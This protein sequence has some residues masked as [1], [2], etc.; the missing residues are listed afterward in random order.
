MLVVSSIFS[1][2]Q[3][4]RVHD[5]GCDDLLAVPLSTDELHRHLAQVGSIPYRG[6]DRMAMNATAHLL[7]SGRRARVRL[8]DLSLGGAGVVADEVF[9]VGAELALELSPEA[10]AIPVRVVW[11][12]P[13]ARGGDGIWL[14]LQFGP[15][16]AA[17]RALVEE[18][19]LF[20]LEVE[21]SG[22]VRVCL[23][24]AID[25]TTDLSRLR[26]RLA[27]EHDIV[28]NMREVRYISSA[29]LRQWCALLAD[30][31]ERR[32]AFRHASLAFTSQVAMVPMAAGSGE[33]LSFE[34]PYRCDTCDRDELRLLESGALLCDGD[35]VIPPTL[36]CATCGDDLLFDDLPERYLAFARGPGER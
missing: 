12:T 6:H 10:P 29:G 1:R 8:E 18:L 16:T 17:A 11:V 34:A 14:G 2:R 20:D 30:L 21:P 9:E 23:H 22:A 26:E 13:Q 4:E 15:M 19:C 32:Y 25:E 35:D 31:G 33:I 3:L 24:G 36:R 28:F 27:G 5:C 7:S